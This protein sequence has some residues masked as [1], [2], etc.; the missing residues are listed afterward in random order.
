[1]AVWEYLV[2]GTELAMPHPAFVLVV[3]G[4]TS[5]SHQSMSAVQTAPLIEEVTPQLVF[6]N[7]FSDWNHSPQLPIR[8]P[9]P[10]VPFPHAGH[11]ILHPHPIESQ[12]AAVDLRFVELPIQGQKEQPAKMALHARQHKGEVVQQDRVGPPET[13]RTHLSCDGERRHF[14]ADQRRLLM[15]APPA[16]GTRTTEPG[17]YRG[18]KG[19]DWDGKGDHSRNESGNL[20][21]KQESRRY[22]GGRKSRHC[23]SFC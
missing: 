8:T 12:F 5:S 6:L 13:G 19:C 9:C 23:S 10:R 14:D 22:R 11:N 4:G 21:K 7:V 18:Q 1:M 2:L 16:G 17:P 3:E 15:I 20:K